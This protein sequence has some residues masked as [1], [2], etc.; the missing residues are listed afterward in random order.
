MKKTTVLLAGT[1][2]TMASF[3]SLAAEEVN[4]YS[5]RQP[6]LVEPMFESFTKDTGVKVNVVFA[7]KGL[8]ERLVR[9]GK[10]SPADVVLPTDISQM[11]K[12]VEKGVTQ[13]VQSDAI[14]KSIPEQYRDPNG[15]WYALTLRIR[16][17]YSAKRNGKPEDISYEDLAKPEFK[18]KVCTRSGK[19]PYNLSLVSSMI[20]YKGEQQTKAW[21]EGVKANLARRPQGNDRA[22]VKAIKEGVCDYSL[23]NSYYFGQMMKRDDQREWAES[24]YINFPNQGNRGANGNVSGMVM[25]KHAPNKANAQTLMEYLAGEKAQSVYAEVNMEYPINKSVPVSKTVAAWGDFKA[26]DMSL[27]QIAANQAKAQK[28]IDEVQFDH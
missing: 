10:Y 15:H 13:P 19:H 1:A 22:Q 27:V 28:L 24:V 16:N 9:E 20:A 4:V 14:N 17:I 6:F 26:E 25:A 12:L 3:S 5:Y 18:G 23:G 7:K 11:V 2:L 21:L 8:D